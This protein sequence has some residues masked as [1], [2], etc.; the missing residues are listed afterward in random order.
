MAEYE[1]PIGDTAGAQAKWR[2]L[3]SFTQGYI[4]AAFFTN[5]NSGDD[6]DLEGA[7]FAEIADSALAEIVADCAKWQADNSGL[8]DMAY[9]RNG[10]SAIQAGR[11]YWFTRNGHGV[12]FW[13]RKPLEHGKLGDALSKACRYRDI[14]PYRGDDKLIYFA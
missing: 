2:A 4:E 6:E 12:G 3:D 11:D 1:L 5:A 10:Y 13:D 14:S 7:S 8:L 9:D